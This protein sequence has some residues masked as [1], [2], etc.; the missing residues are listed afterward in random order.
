M[1]RSVSARVGAPTGHS[2]ST[3]GQREERAGERGGAQIPTHRLH[4]ARAFPPL[5]ASR[6]VQV[7]LGTHTLS[8]PSR[9]AF[10][11]GSPQNHLP[12]NGSL[13]GSSSQ[14]G[15][16]SQPPCP[17][18]PPL[19]SK[20]LFSPAILMSGVPP[21]FLGLSHCQ[22]YA[23]AVRGFSDD[24]QQVPSSYRES[25]LCSPEMLKS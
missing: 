11:E 6:R 1:R 9:P 8:E 10:P 3:A 20:R 22:V 15:T 2:V 19:L 4:P 12:S 24:S 13:S 14:M 17:A 25:K 18:G 16:P 21:S 23:V 7:V 5:L